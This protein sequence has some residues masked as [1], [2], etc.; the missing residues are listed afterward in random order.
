MTNEIVSSLESQLGIKLKFLSFESHLA[1]KVCD[2]LAMC[3]QTFTYLK[4]NNKII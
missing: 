2:M 1:L 3:W 4:H